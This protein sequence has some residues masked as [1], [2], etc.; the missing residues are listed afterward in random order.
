MCKPVA[1][2]A[3][4]FARNWRKG[5][6]PMQHLYSSD[7][8]GT[9]AAQERAEQQAAYVE[10]V[11]PIWAKLLDVLGMNVQYTHASGAELYTNDGRT[12]LDCLSGYC[13]HNAGHNHPYIVT[14][15]F[16]ELQGQPPAMLQGN[17]VE[18]AGE[19]AQALCAY[20]N[21][22]VS[23]A[24]FAVP[25]AK[26]SKRSSSSLAHTQVEETSSMLRELFMG[27]PAARYP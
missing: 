8:S 17:V 2:D 6:M 22:K 26:G 4:A 24:F 12:I 9:L 5:R 27:L 7:G 15:L 3:D 14:Q 11:N 21:G 23:K 20:A 18:S 16:A 25:E 10:H 13:V 1:G 19:L